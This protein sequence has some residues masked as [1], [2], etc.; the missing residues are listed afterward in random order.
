MGGKGENGCEGSVLGSQKLV[1]T[2]VCM[3][4]G[5]HVLAC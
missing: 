4:M 1:P 5:C 2:R 3:R